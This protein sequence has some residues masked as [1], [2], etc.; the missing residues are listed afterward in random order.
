SDFRMDLSLFFT[1][2]LAALWYLVAA[3]TG[4]R[5]HFALAGAACGVA[6]L[7]RAT[8]PV[9]IA[10]ALAPLVLYDVATG[11]RRRELLAGCLVAGL[12]ATGMSLWFYV[13]NF[14]QL[15]YYYFVWNPDANAHL[16]LAV[17]ARH[18]RFVVGH[19]GLP[20]FGFVG[21]LYA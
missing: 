2:A 1:F 11:P 6:F 17:S 10:A 8:A 15:Y 14:G 20:A 18:F 21:A 13:I 4:R 5:R 7:F 16:P 12:T 19:I 9:Y 3:A